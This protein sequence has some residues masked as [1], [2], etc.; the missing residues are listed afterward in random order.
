MNEIPVLGFYPLYDDVIIPKYETPQSACFDLRAYLPPKEKII[1]YNSTLD[2][3][4]FITG[5]RSFYIEPNTTALIPTG[6][7][8]DIPR[9]Y[10][11][12]LHARSGLALKNG[13]SLANSE[14]VIDSDYVEEV[15]IM[16]E[17]RSRNGYAIRHQDRISQGELVPVI[18]CDFNI[19]QS[20]P[21]KKTTRDGG[22]GSTGN[23]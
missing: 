18:H 4:A 6:L 7:I 17:N 10:S 19:L 13:L 14:G 3:D 12:R 22:F 11:V 15:F 2:S 20:R 8:M 5:N 21:N 23:K 9:G 16:I 1:T